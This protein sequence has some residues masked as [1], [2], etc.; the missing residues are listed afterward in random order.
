MKVY[1]VV[2]IG[3]GAAGLGASYVLRTKPINYLVLEASKRAG[4]RAHTITHAKTNIDLGA[5]WLHHGRKNVLTSLAKAQQ[6]NL[7]PV[8]L[9]SFATLPHAYDFETAC[10][11]IDVQMEEAANKHHDQ[12][13]IEIIK[14]TSPQH[15]A[16]AYWMCN[17]DMGTEPQKT[18]VMSWM[19]F[20]GDGE[21]LTCPQGY[22]SIIE[23]GYS[24][25]PVNYNSIVNHIDYSKENIR[26]ETPQ[27]TFQAKACLCTAS[28][29]VLNSRMIN[30][31][32]ELPPWKRRAFN[33]VQMGQ[34]LKVYLELNESHLF[35]DD[36]WIYEPHENNNFFFYHLKPASEPWIVVYLGGQ[37]AVDVGQQSKEQIAQ[38]L[39]TPLI[40]RYQGNVGTTF[41]DIFFTDWNS[42]P[43]TLGAYASHRPG[44]FPL[45]D[46]LARPIDGKIFFAG[47]AFAGTYGQ[48]VDGAFS[49]GKKAAQEI[50][51]HLLG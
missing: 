13:A 16:A 39:Q 41:G 47:E 50:V 45:N 27:G 35:P 7:F 11:L 30:F 22:G 33:D 15:H 21:N 36:T 4:G 44:E 18:S 9:E 2:V 42:N 43:Y 14:N 34:L 26:L 31:T 49:S 29:G 20:A 24:Y 37:H 5:G 25:V 23:D 8:G 48:T 40:N 17:I 32:P 10:S 38:I 12:P 51:K 19:Q 1:D 6:K 28:M 46:N 3:A